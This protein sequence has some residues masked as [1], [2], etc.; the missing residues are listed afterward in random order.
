LNNKKASST[1]TASSKKGETADN[2][3]TLH[4]DEEDE[5]EED[6]SP[7]ASKEYD[8]VYETPIA[9]ARPR[10][11]SKTERELPDKERAMLEAFRKKEEAEKK[12]QGVFDR[13]GYDYL[14]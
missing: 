8:K 13:Y 4:D 12:R 2:A 7:K 9:A 11:I 14:D 3:L 1:T 10:P 6:Q 5:D